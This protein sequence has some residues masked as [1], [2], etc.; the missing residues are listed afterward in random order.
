MR[1][2]VSGDD[3]SGNAQARTYAEY[4]VFAVLA[5]YARLVRGARVVLHRGDRRGTCESVVCSVTVALKP[6]GQARARA[7]GPHAYAAINRAVERLA[8]LMGRRTAQ[9]VSS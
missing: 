5:R 7:S 1:I 8:G 9:R 4:K 3:G 2:H 6:S